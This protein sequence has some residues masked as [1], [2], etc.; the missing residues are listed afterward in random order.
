MTLAAPYRP[1]LRAGC[2]RVQSA[3]YCAQHAPTEEERGYGREHRLLRTIGRARARCEN[4]GGRRR[5][6]LDHRIPRSLGGTNEPANLRWLCA[7]CHGRLGVR[8]NANTPAGA[9][10]R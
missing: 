2:P 4:C 6:Q 1:C 10:V 3:P 8:V 7:S 9:T 5:P